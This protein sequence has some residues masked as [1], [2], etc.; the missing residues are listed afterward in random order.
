MEF[1]TCLNIITL[2]LGC[3]LVEVVC[4]LSHYLALFMDNLHFVY[5]VVYEF[6]FHLQAAFYLGHLAPKPD[7]YHLV[8]RLLTCFW[9][10]SF[11]IFRQFCCTPEFLKMNCIYWLLANVVCNE[12][13][14]VCSTFLCRCIIYLLSAYS[15]VSFVTLWIRFLLSHKFFPATYISV[16]LFMSNPG[17]L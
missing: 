4:I 8:Q 11:S 6:L 1:S 5:N 16:S 9:P 3:L 7:I 17:L 2:I 10:Q 15:I 12:L 13:T 14:I